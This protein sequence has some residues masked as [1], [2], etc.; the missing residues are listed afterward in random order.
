LVIPE[1]MEIAIFHIFLGGQGTL[2][3]PKAGF[4]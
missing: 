3:V 2:S 1:I 4:G